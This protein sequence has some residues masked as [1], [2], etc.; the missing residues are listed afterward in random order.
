V[1]LWVVSAKAPIREEEILQA[2]LVKPSITDFQGQRR[3]WMDIR[4]VCGPIIEIQDGHVR[5]VHFTA[6]E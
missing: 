4:A 1:L 2:V 6:Q 3:A 5:F